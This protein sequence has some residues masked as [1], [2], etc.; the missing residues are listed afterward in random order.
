MGYIESLSSVTLA[1]AP[2]G[3]ATMPSVFSGLAGLK[4]AYNMLNNLDSSGNNKP[5]QINRTISDATFDIANR[6]LNVITEQGGAGSQIKTSD[7]AS[8]SFC[9]I[10]TVRCSNLVSATNTTS[11][12]KS[13]MGDYTEDASGTTTGFRV[14]LSTDKL[15]FFC[16][17]LA[18]VA[19]S[20]IDIALPVSP[21]NKWITVILDISRG[22]TIKL[23]TNTGI[24]LTST[25]SN[26]TTY[27]LGTRDLQFGNQDEVASIATLG[28]IGNVLHGAIF[29]GSQS[30]A[31][32]TEL[33]AR[34]EKDFLKFG[35]A[36]T[37]A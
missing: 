13:I 19:S 3:Y 16:K 32:H 33:F 31:F 6:Y 20:V 22:G 18:G 10:T 17:T 5:L 35:R 36:F 9:M 4:G 1:N 14:A 8:N 28:M 25:D 26:F 15:T 7:L 23:K 24:S 12:R 30:D 37:Y 2:L 29:E 21:L 34:A 27:V 11:A